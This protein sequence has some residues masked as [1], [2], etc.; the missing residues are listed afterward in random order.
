MIFELPFDLIVMW[1]TYPPAPAVP[2]TLLFFLPLF[3]VEVSSFAMLTLSPVMKLS[4]STL[5]L[6]AGI[7]LIFAVCALFGFAYPGSPIPVALINFAASQAICSTASC[8][9]TSQ[10]TLDQVHELQHLG[11][12]LDFYALFTTVLT[13]I[14][15][16]GYVATG[17]L[18][19]WRKSDERSALVASFYL[20]TFGAA[21]QGSNLLLTIGPTLRILTLGLAFVGN[22]CTGFFFYLF[23]TGRFAQRWTCWLLVVWI[24][25]W[26]YTNLLLGSILT[27]SGLIDQL[28]FFGFLASVVAIQ[29]YRYRR[30]STSLQRQQ[31]KWVVY[32]LSLGLV[33]LLF[34]ITV[35]SELSLHVGIVAY[36][37]GDGLIYL[38]LLLIPLS[39]GIA[40]LRSRLYDNL[41]PYSTSMVSPFCYEIP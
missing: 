19:F 4:R 14:F 29:V 18:I 12:S 11:L 32:G 25:Y 9:N 31:T 7:F 21:F 34:L 33:G 2:F 16:I 22:V 38:F 37:V 27:G 13:I 24:A 3:L 15:E 10:L 20:V 1:R 17:A 26:G 23:P 8:G 30:V 28:I 40:I 6:L 39:I 35:G 5:F 41:F 36:L